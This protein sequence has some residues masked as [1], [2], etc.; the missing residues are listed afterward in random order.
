M[1]HFIRPEWL[2][3]LLPVAVISLLFWR[4]HSQQSAWKQY[5]APHL[6]QLLITQSVTNKSQPKW[7]LTACWLI[8]VIALAGPAV[9]KQN[10]PVFAQAF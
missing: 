8:A 10:L 7:L 4:R 6:S 5:I 2:L 1:V 3:A 9:N